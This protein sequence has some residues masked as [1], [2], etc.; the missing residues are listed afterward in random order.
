M[1]VG[2]PAADRRRGTR[3]ALFG[4]L[5]GRA[6]RAVQDRTRSALRL[7]SE[8]HRRILRDAHELGLRPYD[9]DLERAAVE[10]L[11]EALAVMRRGKAPWR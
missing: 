7:I 3:S 1:S 11:S 8:E 2:D 9:R 5:A 4:T 10:A 6:P